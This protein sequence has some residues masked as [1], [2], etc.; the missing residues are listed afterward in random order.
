MTHEKKVKVQSTSNQKLT[1][2]YTNI[3]K[4]SSVLIQPTHC[5]SLKQPSLLEE[6]DSVTTYGVSASIKEWN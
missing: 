6:V 1:R 5:L 4:N 3:I 2:E